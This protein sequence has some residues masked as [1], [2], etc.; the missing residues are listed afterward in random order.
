MVSTTEKLIHYPMVIGDELVGS[1]SQDL[2]NPAT[3]E[4]FATVAMGSTADV[5]RAVAAAKAAQ[6]GWAAL[7]IR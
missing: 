4:V 1:G 6:P 5:D 2:I 7:A 3:G